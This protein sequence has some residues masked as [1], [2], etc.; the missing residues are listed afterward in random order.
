VLAALKKQTNKKNKTSL[1][2]GKGSIVA[3]EI[4]NTHPFL[5][6]LQMWPWNHHRQAILKI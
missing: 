2:A 6:P 1:V 4:Q 5:A 3:S